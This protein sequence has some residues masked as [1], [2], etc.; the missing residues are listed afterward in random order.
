MLTQIGDVEIWRVL[1]QNAPFLTPEELWPEAGEDVAR[2]V[3]EKVSG[4][5]DA[6][7]GRLI[8]PVQGFL[9]KTPAHV[10]LVDSCVGNHKTNNFPDWHMRDESRFEAGLVA[11]GV[12]F[13]EVDYVLCTHLHPDHVGWNTKLENGTWVPTFPNAKYLLPAADEEMLRTADVPFYNESV[14]P[15][16]E[17][18]QAELVQPGHMLGDLVRLVPTPGH[19]PGHVAIEITSQGRTALITGDALHC[20]AQCWHP[21]WHFV[22]DADGARAAVSRRALLAHAAEARSLVLGS[23]FKLPSIG[24]VRTDGDA[25][26]WEDLE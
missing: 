19:S 5:L 11:A 15:V 9:L 18:G 17:A 24:H 13:D 2:I 3:E 23:H 14:L 6:A 16:I 10:I 1:E 25:F 20:T 7:S 8:L 26:A 12:G 21:E 4:A 22:Y